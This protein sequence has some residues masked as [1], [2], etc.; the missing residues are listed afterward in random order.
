MI[1]AALREHK[2]LAILFY[3]PAGAD[4]EAV[5]HELASIPTHRGRVVKLIVPVAELSRYTTITTQVMVSTTPTL[6]L[7]G[8]NH[9]ASTITGFESSFELATRV[10]NLV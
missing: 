4:D 5:K 7:I 10:A 3:N 8:R 1:S 9:Q 2:V 6:V